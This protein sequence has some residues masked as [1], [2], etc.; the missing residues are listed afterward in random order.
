MRP[1]LLMFLLVLPIRADDWTVEGKDFHNVKVGQVDPDKVHIT[2]DGGIGTV[3]L[4]DLTPELQK[5]F[6]YDPAKAKATID[7]N[8]KARLKAVADDQAMAAKYAAATAPPQTTPQAAPWV[9][10]VNN[11]KVY[12]SPMAHRA[13]SPEQ[14]YQ[15]QQAYQQDR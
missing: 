6:G 13:E 3:L 9:V 14:F 8:E 2:Y 12:I 5:R 1:M 10:P 15:N 7:A 11:A 4:S